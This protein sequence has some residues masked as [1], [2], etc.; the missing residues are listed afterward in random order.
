M[1]S[2]I[3]LLR[4]VLSSFLAVAAVSAFADDLP[5]T[6]SINCKDRAEW[7]EQVSEGN[8]EHRGWNSYEI[9]LVP[10][11]D[12]LF[13]LAYGVDLEEWRI[14]GSEI[15]ASHLMCYY[16]Q[17]DILHF[18][19]DDI[20]KNVKY[21]ARFSKTSAENATLYE[22]DLSPECTRNVRPIYRQFDS[23]EVSK[24]KSSC[25]H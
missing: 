13:E 11:V 22:L 23:F 1:M 25:R 19:C 5:L 9:S 15:V 16:P 21:C 17:D 2:S 7:R 3:Y 6:A 20:E 14:K 24:M 8:Y 4:S 18:Y 10:G 12:G